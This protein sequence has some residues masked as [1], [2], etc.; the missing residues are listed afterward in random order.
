VPQ[1]VSG[2]DHAM[3]AEQRDYVRA[4]QDAPDAETKIAWCSLTARLGSG[5]LRVLVVMMRC[6][7]AGVV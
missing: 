3:P 7:P 5:P 2:T 4:I 1:G 6:M